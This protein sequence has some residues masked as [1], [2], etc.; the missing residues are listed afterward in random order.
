MQSVIET[1]ILA[2]FI[3]T[4]VLIASLI[5]LKRRKLEL[6]TAT[7]PIL[8]NKKLCQIEKHKTMIY[9]CLPEY[10]LPIGLFIKLHN[11]VLGIII[12]FTLCTWIFSFIKIFKIRKKERMKINL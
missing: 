7:D 6:K 8:K 9:L 11:I 5:M 3:T 10:I 4:V 2:L 12:I 1:I